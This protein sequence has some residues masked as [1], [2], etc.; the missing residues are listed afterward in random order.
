MLD[1]IN[2]LSHGMTFADEN[3]ISS[4]ELQRS[5]RFLFEVLYNKDRFHV[6]QM[7]GDLINKSNKY[8][9]L[10]WLSSLAK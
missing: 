10:T 3:P 6:E 4:R 2:S 5:I 9:I 1:V 7:A 8:D